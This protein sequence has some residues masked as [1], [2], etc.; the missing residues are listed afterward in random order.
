MQELVNKIL[1]ILKD[2]VRQNNLEINLNQEE[3]SKLL[4]ESD[5]SPK[6]S[7]DLE[8]KR[9]LNRELLRE[10]DDF[11]NM[12]LQITEFMEKYGHLIS[13]P[14]AIDEQEEEEALMPY[15]NQTIEGHIEYGP[16]HPQ[17]YNPRFFNELLRYYQEK[18]DYEKCDQLV[19]LKRGI[20]KF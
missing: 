20:N 5:T 4:S 9:S 13:D 3:I 17:F 8:Y 10:N 15:F 14:D 1:R 11:M 6:E 12:Q 7:D 19:K 16:D 18:E 2:H